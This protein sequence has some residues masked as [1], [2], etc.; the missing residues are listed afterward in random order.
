MIL[1]YKSGVCRVISIYGP[2]IDPVTKEKDVF[3]FGVDFIG[4]RTVKG[5]AGEIVSVSNGVVVQS[6]LTKDYGNP[7]WVLGNYVVILGDDGVT[8]SYCHLNERCVK[9]GDK[10]YIGDVIGT[11]GSTGL[12]AKKHLH[13]ECHQG[14]YHMNPLIYLGIPHGCGVYNTLTLEEQAEETKDA[15][16]RKGCIVTVL[17]RAL[18]KSGRRVPGTV[19]KHAYRVQ[20]VRDKFALLDGVDDWIYIGHLKKKR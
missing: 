8:V 18:Y 6:Y 3:H 19:T 13:L 4:E 17:P 15:R 5:S 11:E 12:V 1:P 7:D 9:V 16:I 20:M 10:V 2:R 14:K